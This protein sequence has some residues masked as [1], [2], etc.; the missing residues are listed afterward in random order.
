MPVLLLHGK[1]D[2]VVPT[3]QSQR[4]AR[5]LRKEGKSHRLSVRPDC[6]HEL[7]VESC[8]TGYFTEVQHFLRDVLDGDP[9]ASR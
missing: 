6:D 8:R 2:A 4:F 7:T 3:T 1:R 5:A 9:A